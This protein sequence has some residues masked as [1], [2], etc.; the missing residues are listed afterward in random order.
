MI[1]RMDYYTVKCDNCGKLYADEY[2]GYSAWNDENGAMEYASEADWIKED[3]KHYCPD[4]YEYDDD[5]N[6]IIKPVK[7]GEASQHEA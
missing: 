4:C 5:D 3:D 6:L 1:L 2:S 7:N